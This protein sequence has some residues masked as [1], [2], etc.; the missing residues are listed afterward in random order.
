MVLGSKEI[1]RA[2]VNSQMRINPS[3]ETSSNFTFA[4][5]RDINRIAEIYI[6]SIHVPFSFYAISNYN[7]TFTLNNNN[8]TITIPNG[9]Y[10]SSSICSTLKTLFDN[11]FNDTTTVVTFSYITFKLTISRG[12]AFSIDAVQY[13]YTNAAKIL[14][15]NISTPTALSV[16]SDSAV[17]LSGPNYIVLHSKILSHPINNKILYANDNYNDALAII[18][19]DVGIGDIISLTNAIPIPVKYNYKFNYSANTPID[20]IITDEFGNILDMNGGD[21]AIQFT[22]ITE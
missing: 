22:F 10:T 2:V 8:V 14:G 17:N 15:F 18:P 21:V 11:A 4:F 20:F 9:N 7:N 1:I 19:V 6:S 5:E 16:T 3:T 13:P 12:I